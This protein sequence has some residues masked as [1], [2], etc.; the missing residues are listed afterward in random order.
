[1]TKQSSSGSFGD[2]GRWIATSAKRPPRNDDGIDFCLSI[3]SCLVRYLFQL[4][5]ERLAFSFRLRLIDGN[6][7]EVLIVA[8]VHVELHGALR[9][10]FGDLPVYD[11]LVVQRVLVSEWR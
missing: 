1:M 2:S 7:P 9:F 11:D 8:V 6:E 10:V 3:I 4:F 5:K